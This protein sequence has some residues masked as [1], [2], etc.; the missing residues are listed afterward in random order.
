[1]D[2]DDDD[3]DDQDGMYEDPSE[4]KERDADIQQVAT[5]CVRVTEHDGTKYYTSTR[6]NIP[7][8]V[9][10]ARARRVIFHF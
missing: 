8:A 2:D 9:S 1:M 6:I 7:L 4:P 5:G 3:D 10:R